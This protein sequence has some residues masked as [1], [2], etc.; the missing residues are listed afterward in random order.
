VRDA[1]ERALKAHYAV[2]TAVDGRQ[3]LEL[4]APAVASLE[5]RHPATNRGSPIS[6]NSIPCQ[7]ARRE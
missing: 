3:A 4:L 1:F 2:V 7:G 5:R 6:K